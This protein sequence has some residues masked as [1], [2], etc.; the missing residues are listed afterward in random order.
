[1]SCLQSYNLPIDQQ[2]IPQALPEVPHPAS[3]AVEEAAIQEIA[4]DEVHKRAEVEM[5]HGTSD[6]H[7]VV[8]QHFKV[9]PLNSALRP[10]TYRPP[11]TM[12]YTPGSA[13]S[14]RR[15]RA[16]ESTSIANVIIKGNATPPGATNLIHKSKITP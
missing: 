16:K 8:I 13:N 7:V 2:T 1:M 11:D 9:C 15:A 14:N 12:R 5:T 3:T 6:K 4:D 10:T